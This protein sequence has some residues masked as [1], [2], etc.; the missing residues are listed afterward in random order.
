MKNSYTYNTIAPLFANLFLYNTGFQKSTNN[1]NKKVTTRH[2]EQS[3]IKL[4]ILE[5]LIRPVHMDHLMISC[6]QIY[7]CRYC[8]YKLYHNSSIRSDEGLALETS[9]FESL[10]GG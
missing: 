6:R 5:I 8:I 10:Y 3:T 2:T 1:K 4:L 7:M 9:A